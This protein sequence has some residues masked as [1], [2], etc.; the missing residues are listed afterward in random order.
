MFEV[1][2]KP[3]CE[4]CK[5]YENVWLDLNLICKS[6]KRNKKTEKKK[7]KEKKEK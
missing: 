7:R 4:F 3:C 1:G 2:L 5:I 6:Y